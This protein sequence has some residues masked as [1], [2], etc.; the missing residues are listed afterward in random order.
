VA[1]GGTVDQETP[2][3]DSG[4]VKKN[5]SCGGKMSGG[6]VIL[7]DKQMNNEI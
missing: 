5:A 7:S 1:G 4:H 6:L 2:L 3:M